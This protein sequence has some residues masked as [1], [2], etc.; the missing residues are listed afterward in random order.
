MRFRPPTTN[1]HISEGI[2]VCARSAGCVAKGAP[3]GRRCRPT[4]RLTTS[5]WQAYTWRWWVFS[6][7]SH[8]WCVDV[9][10]CICWVI[11]FDP[12]NALDLYSGG[13]F[14]PNVCRMWQNAIPDWNML[15][16][17]SIRDI[18]E[19]KTP[20][21]AF[22]WR[23]ALGSQIFIRFE[24]VLSSRNQY[25]LFVSHTLDLQNNRNTSAIVCRLLITYTISERTLSFE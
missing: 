18:S 23:S 14:S 7:I 15:P 24:Q 21:K 13:G 5:T 2:H 12:V 11:D 16:Y 6:L 25:V 17:T 19:K 4:N 9:C 10:V 20:V 3:N 1:F 8:V 22:Y